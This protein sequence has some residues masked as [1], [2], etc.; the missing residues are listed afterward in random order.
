MT[1]SENSTTDSATPTALDIIRNIIPDA[2]RQIIDSPE[3]SNIKQ[4]NYLTRTPASAE[5]TAEQIVTPRGEAVVE[6]MDLN[7]IAMDFDNMVNSKLATDRF[8]IPEALLGN[9]PKSGVEN[10]FPVESLTTIPP[11]NDLGKAKVFTDLDQRQSLF[12]RIR[13]ASL[14]AEQDKFFDAD[15][16]D[17]LIQIKEVDAAQLGGLRAWGGND[18][19]LG[20]DVNDIVNGNAGNDKIVGAGGHDLLKGGQGKDLIAGGDGE[21]LL[22]GNKGDDDLFGGAGNDVI[23][24]GQGVDVLM[25]NAGNDIL[26]GRA[27][28]DFLMGSEGADQFI[29]RGETLVRSAAEADRILDFNPSEGDLIK[30]AYF[31]GTLAMPEITCAA[32][33]VN[34][35]SKQDTAILCSGGVVGVI[36]SKDPTEIMNLKS[37]IFMVNPKDTALSMIGDHF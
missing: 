10:P 8:Q 31:D 16:A 24:G 1:D 22:L 33:D 23:R 36:L 28:G 12:D 29:L 13:G 3:P 32:V 34:L 30:I 20:T 25:G 18:K 35:D 7:Q 26:I 37:S 19:I 9:S 5:Q 6:G 11:I 14:G 2:L 15:D 4:A 17:N 21:D 27:D